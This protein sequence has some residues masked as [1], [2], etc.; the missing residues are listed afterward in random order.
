MAIR[1]DTSYTLVVDDDLVSMER[2][3]VWGPWCRRARAML[4]KLS[5]NW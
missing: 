4:R 3:R 5:V 2:G 1:V